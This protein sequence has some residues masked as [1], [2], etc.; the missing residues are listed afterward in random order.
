MKDLRLRGRRDKMAWINIPFLTEKCNQFIK[1]NIQLKISK[2]VYRRGSFVFYRESTDFFSKETYESSNFRISFVSD[3]EGTE[4]WVVSYLRHT[5]K[6][7]DLPIFGE[8]DS[9]LKEIKSG[10]FAILMPSK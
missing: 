5:G 7:S 6:W 4:G 9:C 8:F 3:K 1:K 10:D 2:C